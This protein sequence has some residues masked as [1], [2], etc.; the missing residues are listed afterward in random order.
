M[1]EEHHGHHHH[2]LNDEEMFQ[3]MVAILDGKER[4]EQLS[5]EEIIQYLPDLSDKTIFDGGA[6]TGFLSL[7]LAEKAAQVIAFDQSEKMLRLV[8]ERA[9]K[10]ELS[11]LTTMAGDIKKI[12]LSDNSVDLAIVSV[13][14]H[15]VHPFKEALK[16]LERIITPDGQFVI[17]EFESD[18]HQDEGGHRIPSKV[19]R[20]E[21]EALNFPIVESIIPE[22]GMYLFIVGKK[23][24]LD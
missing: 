23:N 21:L 9:E 17:L 6:G 19:M 4:E 18:T 16:E 5:A 7:P 20:N 2:D 15:E 24:H 22:E 8:Q 14:I 10:K 13:M 11:N 12:P 1:T 3:R